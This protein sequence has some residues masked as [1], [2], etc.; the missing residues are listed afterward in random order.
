MKGPRKGAYLH[1]SQKR[2]TYGNRH[3]FLEPYLEYPLE[4]P[5]KEPSIHVPLIELL[6]REMPHS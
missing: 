4:S 2:Y 6:R 5:V 3:P 1:F